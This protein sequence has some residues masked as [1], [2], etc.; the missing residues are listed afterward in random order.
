MKKLKWGLRVINAY[1]ISSRSD[2]NQQFNF[3]HF[4]FK[5]AVLS[6]KN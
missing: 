6:K 3:K 2:L 1:S 4:Q 5:L